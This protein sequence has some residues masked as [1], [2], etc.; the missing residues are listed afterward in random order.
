MRHGILSQSLEFG[1]NMELRYQVVTEAVE[2]TLS[3]NM[4][5][6]LLGQRNWKLS[7]ELFCE[8]CSE[9]A[10]LGMQ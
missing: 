9:N 5:S 1:V 10:I 8:L 3:P 6:Y 2:D 4:S 7:K